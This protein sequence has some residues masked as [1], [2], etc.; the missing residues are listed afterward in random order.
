MDRREFLEASVIALT[1]IPLFTV[2]AQAAG[3]SDKKD[4]GMAN[5]FVLIEIQAVPG[6]EDE[7]RETFVHVIKTSEKPGM[8]SARIFENAKEPGRLY[9][10]QEWEDEAAF[11]LHMSDNR[12]GLDD[13]MSALRGP[14]SLTILKGLG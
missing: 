13:R 12:K 4:D 2:T 6:K 3:T 14:P 9:S 11:R 8:I 10:L 5:I 1:A 7:L